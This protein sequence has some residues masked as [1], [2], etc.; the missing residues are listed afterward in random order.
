MWQCVLPHVCPTPHMASVCIYCPNA[1]SMI[2]TLFHCAD[3]PCTPRGQQCN[4]RNLLDYVH[5]TKW[6]RL[7]LELIGDDKDAVAQLNITEKDHGSDTDT[8]L[9]KTLQLL[10]TRDPNLS[11]QKVVEALRSIGE[12][13]NA[14]DIEDK[15]C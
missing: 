12:I 5:T 3:A 8:A 11:W 15:F 7:G 2:I 4:L 6:Y 13:R 14:K 1:S 10:W 9:R